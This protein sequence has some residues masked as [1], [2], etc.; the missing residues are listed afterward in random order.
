MIL[1]NSGKGKERGIHMK[2][3]FTI[4][5]FVIA[6]LL[7]PYP[8]YINYNIPEG[9]YEILLTIMYVPIIYLVL[10]FILLLIKGKPSFFRNLNYKV[11]FLP[12]FLSIYG[13]FLIYFWLLKDSDKLTNDIGFSY[14]IIVSLIDWCLFFLTRKPQESRKRQ[15]IFITAGF[16]ISLLIYAGFFFMFAITH[17]PTN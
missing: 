7:M 4:L 11:L 6:V 2:N 8:L 3:V 9:P 13:F 12:F 10:F 1:A 15:I 16:I 5:I 17:I 14:I